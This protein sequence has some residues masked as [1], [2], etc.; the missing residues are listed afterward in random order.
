MKKYFVQTKYPDGEISGGMHTPQQIIDMFGFRDCSGCE[1]EVYDVSEFGKIVKL[2][3]QGDIMS[4]SN[5]HRL[6]N[7]LTEDTVIEGYSPEH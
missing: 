1:F 3:E 6:T 5:Y 7:I 4:P 2:E